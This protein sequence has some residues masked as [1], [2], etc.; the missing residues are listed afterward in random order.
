MLRVHQVC[1]YPAHCTD[2]PPALLAL[3]SHVACAR[4][5]R[6]CDFP[7]ITPRAICRLTPDLTNEETFHIPTHYLAFHIPVHYLSD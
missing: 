1:T 7:P 5:V 2:A 3:T 6:C 4:R